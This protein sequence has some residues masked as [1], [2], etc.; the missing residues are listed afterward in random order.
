LLLNP[1]GVR[2]T[3]AGGQ[4]AKGGDA[5]GR[6]G[7]PPPSER[8]K[9]GAPVIPMIP[10]PGARG[11]EIAHPAYLAH[12]APGVANPVP[13]NDRVVRVPRK[14][15]G[16]HALIQVVAVDPLSTTSRFAAL[17]EQPAKFVDLRLRHGLDPA[18]HFTKQKQ[19]SVLTPGQPFTLADA[20]GSRFEAYD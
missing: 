19:I 11:G 18:G 15:L 14:A 10:Q 17:P 20:A 4:E 1:W 16:P 13:A 12:A 2:P 3:E 6:G 5:F 8:T 7:T 9:V